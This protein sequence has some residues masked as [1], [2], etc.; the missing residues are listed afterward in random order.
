MP[1]ISTNDLILLIGD[2]EVTIAVQRK[3]IQDL[4]VQVATLKE[5]IEM[6]MPPATPVDKATK[7][8]KD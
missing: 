4:Q 7:A 1:D 2:K 3:Q 5:Q 8:T 6:L